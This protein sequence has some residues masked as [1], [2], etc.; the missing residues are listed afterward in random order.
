ML[1]IF[2]L[3][4]QEVK[5]RLQPLGIGLEVS[6]SVKHLI[7][8]HEYDQML[9]ARSLRRA[10]SLI[11]EDVLSEVILSGD[12]KPIDTAVIDLDTFGKPF[13]TNLSNRIHPESDIL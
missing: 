11:I 6:E 5:Q 12:Y 1:E 10:I 8:E 7:C 2:N 9:G 3:R 13:V 4:L